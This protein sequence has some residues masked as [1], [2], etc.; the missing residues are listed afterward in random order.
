MTKN[1]FKS[2]RQN[3]IIFID[4][5]NLFYAQKSLKIKI[6]YQ[7]LYDF[8]HQ[9]KRIVEVRIYLAFDH[10]S[11]KEKKFVEKLENIGYKVVLK[12]LKIIKQGQNTFI[13]KGNLDIELALDAYELQ[14]KYR[15]MALFSGDSDF[16]TLIKKL[17]RKAK[18]CVVFSTRKHVAKE[19]VHSANSYI[20]I[21][22][23]KKHIQKI[24]AKDRDQFT[25][26]CS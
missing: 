22:H 17:K 14:D 19:L 12:K 4:G 8:L 2:F 11:E 10:E 1:I 7:R 26:D 23:F 5:A 21:N 15:T 18:R 13:K 16:L 9:Y 6:D 3:T 25:Q 24:P 20:E